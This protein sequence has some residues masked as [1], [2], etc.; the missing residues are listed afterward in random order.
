M[1]NALATFANQVNRLARHAD[2]VKFGAR[3]VF[4]CSILETWHTVARATC[5]TRPM[6]FAQ[7]AAAHR[8]G[9]VTLCRADLIAAMDPELVKWSEMSAG[10]ATFHFV[11]V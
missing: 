10:N 3:K 9:L 4:L 7:L 6:F 8:A 1:D 5:P 11:E 2:A